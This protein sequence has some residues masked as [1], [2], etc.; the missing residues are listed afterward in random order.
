MAVKD[1]KIAAF[2]PPALIIRLGYVHYYRNSVLIKGFNHSVERIDRIALYD[3]V[4]LLH[5]LD[6]LHPGDL[7]LSFVCLHRFFRSV[8][9]TLTIFYN[10]FKRVWKCRWVSWEII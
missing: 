3:S 1:S 9:E 4:A 2:G 8:Y 5:E 7:M 6:P 10:K